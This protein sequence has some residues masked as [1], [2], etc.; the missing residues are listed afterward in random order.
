MPLSR[1]DGLGGKDA[2]ATFKRL[3]ASFTGME[4]APHWRD[5]VM[6]SAGASDLQRFAYLDS[7]R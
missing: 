5:G 6:M 2:P 1:G 4:C 3:E 7:L